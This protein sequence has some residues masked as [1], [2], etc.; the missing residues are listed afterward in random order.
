VFA[1]E[2]AQLRL[3]L[4]SRAPFDRP[5]ILLRHVAS[6]AQRVAE[7][8]ANETAEVVIAVPAT[9]RGWLDY[10]RVMLETRF[11]LGL[12]RAWS[13][14]EPDARCLVY[15]HPLRSPLPPHSPD[16][17]AGATRAHAPG[18]DDYSGLRAYQLSD[19]PRHVAW[20][21][22]ARS[23]A[24][25]TKQF[26][27]EAAAE[28]ILDWAQLPAGSALEERLS[29]LA[30]WV[31]AAERDGLRYGLRLPG[32]EIAPDHGATHRSACLQALALYNAESVSR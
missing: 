19:S 31:I 13:Y 2:S 24:M 11:P 10:G 27:G 9:K 30:G 15:P 26:A 16:P 8:A 14:V 28:L 5:Q 6:G 21:A 3:Y 22:A 4:A 23:G 20:K 32:L 18:N 17:R 12:F 1:G 29:R 25:L 7:I